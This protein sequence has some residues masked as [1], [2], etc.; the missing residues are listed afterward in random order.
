MGDKGM[1]RAG[2]IIDISELRSSAHQDARNHAAGSAVLG[3]GVA[4]DTGS[5]CP[6]G[7]P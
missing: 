7:I 1:K 3:D 4:K 5:T 2:A 6:L